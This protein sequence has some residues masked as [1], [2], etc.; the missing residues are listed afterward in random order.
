[1]LKHPTR[2]ID[3]DFAAPV[4]AMAV[5]VVVVVAIV[6]AQ[7]TNLISWVVVCLAEDESFP[8]PKSAVAAVRQLWHWR[9]FR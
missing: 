1:M 2:S 8:P 7:L 3:L 9:R 5:V 4:V 6:V